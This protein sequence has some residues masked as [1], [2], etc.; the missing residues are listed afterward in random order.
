MDKQ[1]M[2]DVIKEEL[3]LDLEIDECYTT[4]EVTEAFNIEGFLAPYCV[5]VHR[6]TNIKGTLAFIHHPRIYYG[7]TEA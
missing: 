2:L 1:E 6:E 5:A 7:W 3:D 4:E